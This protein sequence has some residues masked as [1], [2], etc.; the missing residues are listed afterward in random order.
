MSKERITLLVGAS[1]E[2]EK[3]P[4]LAIGKYAKP[5]CFKGAQVPVSYTN[6]PKAWMNGE[7]FVQWLQKLNTQMRAQSRQIALV[8][9]NCPAHPNVGQLSNL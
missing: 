5:R 2:G 6:N 1:M 4:L 9:D 7:L 3:L 8:I